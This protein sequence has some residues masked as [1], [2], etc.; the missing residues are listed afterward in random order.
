MLLGYLSNNFLT[1]S[2]RKY[3]DMMSENSGVGSSK[4]VVSL[5]SET[6]PASMQI[7]CGIPAMKGLRCARKGP[8]EIAKTIGPML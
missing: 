7:R 5:A 6:Q 8:E 4:G 2:I 3:H 1:S